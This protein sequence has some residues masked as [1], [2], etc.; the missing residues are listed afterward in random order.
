MEA[1]EQMLWPLMACLVLVGIHAYLGIHII[2]RKVIFVDLALAQIAGLGAVYGVFIGLNLDSDA[3]L[4]KGVSV[5]FTLFGALL[6]S[7]TR[8]SDERI[9]HEAIIGIIY[10]ATMSMTVLVTANLPHGA[11]EV[12]QMLAGNI[13]WVTKADV[14]YTALLYGAIGLLHVVFRKQFFLLSE[15]IAH[16]HARNINVKL[17]DFLFYASFGVVVTSSVGMGGVLLVFGYL[18]IPS[19][20]GV[21]VAHSTKWR[22]II[23]WSSGALMSVL[24]VV[25]SYHLDLPSGPAIVVL[26]G[27]LLL[28]LALG[29]EIAK[30]ATRRRGIFHVG[31]LSL[32]ACAVLFFPVWQQI[33]PRYSHDHKSTL[34]LMTHGSSKIETVR[35]SLSAENE[36]IVL[37]ALSSIRTYNLVELGPDVVP[38]VLSPSAK[39]RELAV[40][41]LAAL[42]DERARAPLVVAIKKEKDVF[43]KIE[44]AEA[45]LDLGDKQGLLE[46]DTI[47]MKSTSDFARDDARAHLNERVESAPTTATALSSWLKENFHRIRFD[48]SNKKFYLPD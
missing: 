40:K 39:Q 35:Q 48:E 45:L 41:V 4:I 23:G 34:H 36:E 43:I 27:L 8:T 20:I 29:K 12:R 37:K 38:F 15:E 32:L 47:M 6:F 1:F 42:G 24:G 13:L 11:D 22:L 17:W 16:A 25:V 28:V 9:P 10:A 2:A 5:L 21:M 31:I 30:G 46:L 18:V 26:L 33:A 14:G 44:M 7:F 3:W 19:V